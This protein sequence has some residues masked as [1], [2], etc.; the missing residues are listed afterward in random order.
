MRRTRLVP[1]LVSGVALA[2][3]GCGVP[4]DSAPRT[5]PP[6]NVPFGLLDLDT[7]IPSTTV[8]D[9]SLTLEAYLVAGS[10]LAVVGRVMSSPVT[11]SGSLQ[12]LLL[13]P[14]ADEAGRGLRTAI[15]TDSGLSVSPVDAGQVRIEL[16]E[17]FGATSASDQIL[18]IAQIVYTVTAL[19]GVEKA[20]FTLAGRA[21]DVPTGDGTLTSGPLGRQDFPGLAPA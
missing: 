9:V 20:T 10:R 15:G 7:T 6:E 1:W 2:L 8:P 5:I 21:V 19:P 3:V 13:G 4:S 16:G 18:A 12:A 17:S 14:T 11:P